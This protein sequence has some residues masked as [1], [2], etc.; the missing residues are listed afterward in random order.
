MAVDIREHNNEEDFLRF[1]VGNVMFIDSST[2]T[3]QIKIV[4][5]VYGEFWKVQD[6]VRT[7]EKVATIRF[8]DLLC[9]FGGLKSQ[10]KMYAK[11]R[12]TIEALLAVPPN[13][14]VPLTVN[15]E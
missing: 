3:C 5:I 8:P 12:K 9:R 11:D 1:F 10:K 2:C 6:V 14:R 7:G 13:K 15:K 4:E